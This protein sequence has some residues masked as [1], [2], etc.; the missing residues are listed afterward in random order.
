MDTHTEIAGNTAASLLRRIFTAVA[1]DWVIIALLCGVMLLAVIDP[2][3]LEPS[4]RFTLHALLGILPFLLLAVAF[5]TLASVTGADGLVANAFSG[6]PGRAV[7]LAALAGALSPFCSC[8]VVP[9][10]A[11]LLRARVPL[12]PVMAFW[13]ASPVMDPE[14]FILTSAGIS[15]EFALAKTAAAIA[16]GLLA[17]FAVL[18]FR[19]WPSFESPL[20]ADNGGGSCASTLSNRQVQWRFWRVPERRARFPVE[21]RGMSA[22][23]GKWLLLAFFLESLMQ[24]YIPA[25]VIV[26]WLGSGEWYEVPLAAVVGI[27]AYLNGYAAI[28]LVAELMD[29]GMNPGAAMTFIT[30]G[31]VSSIP[32]AMAV[33]VLVKGPV[34][35]VYLLLGVAGSVTTGG[36]YALYAG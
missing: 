11:S 18:G 7:F 8:G 35:A 32:A 24:A 27:P 23:L 17:G 2:D 15:P 30:A 28:P 14:M 33:A 20:A 25:E 22:F 21:F 36:L 10:I 26:R 5:A 3:R 13:I 31:A 34:F 16:M 4:L 9:L 1:S 6:Q 19:K 12:A 29:K